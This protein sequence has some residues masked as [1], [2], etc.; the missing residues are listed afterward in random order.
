VNP[1]GGQAEAPPAAEANPETVQAL[2]ETTW[3]VVDA[4]AARREGLNRKASSLAT[5]AALI[6]SVTSTLGA[7]FL[8]RLDETW[9][10]ALFLA[11]LA[12]L[13]TTIA[14]ALFILLPRG[15]A[16]LGLGYLERFPS[17]SEVTKAPEQVRGETM[18]GLVATLRS[19][20]RQNER[21]ARFLFAAFLFLFVGLALVATEAAVSTIAARP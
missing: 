4:E 7:R 18:S 10:L 3:R 1:H 21:D 19:L 17:W 14:L 9:A 11:S 6:L 15:R 20:R 8:E 12:S 2:L 5:F 13:V 16:T